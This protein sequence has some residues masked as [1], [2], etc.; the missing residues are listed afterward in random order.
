MTTNAGAHT[1]T[2]SPLSGPSFAARAARLARSDRAVYRQIVQHLVE[3]AHRS[4]DPVPADSV[5]RL[6]NADLV[7]V[8]D[9]GRIAVAY[10]FSLHRT[11]HRVVM[12]DGRRYR[13]MCAIDALGIPYLLREPG[14]VHAQEPDNGGMVR[15]EVDPDEDPV[16]TP[17]QAVA[18]VA[19]GDGSCLA[20]CACPHINLF[21][22]SDH[23]E[24]YLSAQGLRGSIL[25]ISDAAVTGR[26]LFGDLL[27]GLAD[28]DPG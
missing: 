27:H 2:D 25:S 9:H 3:N 13:A 22:S 8:D 15:V 6:I 19:S 24:R 21:A 7:Q 28:T 11:R 4:L 20:Q 16:W 26:R 17:K 12:Q 18:V 10:P 14:E 5:G 23:G 1:R